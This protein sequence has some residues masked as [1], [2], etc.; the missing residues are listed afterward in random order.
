L[1]KKGLLQYY[2]EFKSLYWS[3]KAWKYVY[4]IEGT[5][6]HDNY[7][8]ISMNTLEEQDQ[9]KTPWAI[10]GFL[11]AIPPGLN[12]LFTIGG[13]YQNAYK[14]ANTQT[15]CPAST[16]GN[17]VISKTGAIGE[18]SSQQKHLLY[19]E[20]RTEL[21]TLGLSIRISHDFKDGDTGIDFPV[22]IFRNK[23]N[24]LS[25][26]LRM[27]WTDKTHDTT[28]GVFIGGDFSLFQ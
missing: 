12:A 13:Q 17:P 27:G 5:I 26:G 14:A 11:G 4:G 15:I 6:G 28:F 1:K 10:G 25:G 23:K 22:Y 8:F 7:E 19:V 2:P 9:D 3:P 18:P 24:N 16:A 20:D 21:L